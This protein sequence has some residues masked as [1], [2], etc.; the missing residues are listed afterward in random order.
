MQLQD[1]HAM[2]DIS[3]LRFLRL[4]HLPGQSVQKEAIAQRQ[5][6]VFLRRSTRA[7]Q[8]RLETGSREEETSLKA[9]FPALLGITAQD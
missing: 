1:R 5:R 9:A 4:Q 7:L 3:V 6:L 8:L 2:L